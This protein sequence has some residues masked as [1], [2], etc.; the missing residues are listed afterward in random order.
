MFFPRE[1]TE[2]ELIV[3]SKDL[4]AVTQV[5]SGYG[6]FHQTDS[7]YPG[8]ASGSANTW[9]ETAAQYAALERRVQTVMQALGIEEG[10][11]PLSDGQ[12]KGMAEIETIRPLVEQIEGEVRS[13]NDELSELRKRLEQLE[14][15]LHQLEPVED[16]DIDISSLRDSRYMF[17][18]LG[19]MPSANMDRLQTSLARV[20]HVFMTLRSDPG[21]PVV[22]LAGT[23]ANADV[24]QRAARSAYLDPLSLPSDYQGTPGKIIESLRNTIESTQRRIEELEATIGRFGEERKEQLR[25]LLWQAHTSRVL[26]D[27]I[28]RFGQLRHTYVVTGWVP[29]DDLDELSRR[30]KQAS[31]EVLIETLP[32]SRRGHNQNVPVALF[33]NR[34]LKPFQMLVNTYA[35]P[36]YGEIDPTILIAFT[37]PVLYGAMF[38]DLGQGLVLFTLGLLMHNKIILKG[39]SSL[40]LLIA[41]CGVFAALFGVLYGSFFG[42]EGEH[43]AET[44]G[45][46]FTPVWISPIHDILRVLGL[47]IDAGIILLLVGYLLGIYSHARARNWGHL[48]FGHNG[49]IALLFYISF[50]ALL[51]NFLGRTPIAPQVAVAIGSLPL[52]FPIFAIIFGL[53]IMF[54]EVFIHW[55]EGH[56]PL[57]EGRGVGGFIMYLVQAFMDW[58]EVVISQLSNTLSYVRV[59][60]FAVAHGGLSL[61]FFRLAELIGGGEHGVGYWAMLVV[62]NLFFI[63]IEAL[64]VGIQ[65]M[66]LHYYE[67]LGKFFTGGGMRFEPLAVTPTKEEG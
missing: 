28:V 34:F 1:M 23:K 66:R 64:I 9:Q 29:R 47:A 33:N 52:P 49:L 42:F 63:T 41:Y 30:L 3:P 45:F 43:F 37:F 60:A 14:S 44:F 35:R 24:L 65:T 17:S 54:S 40:G 5:L 50:L 21:R 25:D 4:V 48:V 62:G 59:G 31:R 53:G 58:F 56:R 6:V 15:I 36:R 10:Q 38:G 13:T 20:P 11:P 51:G 8:V 2:I 39:M 18:M 46:E 27:A 12:Q 55:M 22:W 7:N 61:A 26:S 16:V 57:I 67:F 19:L 32:T